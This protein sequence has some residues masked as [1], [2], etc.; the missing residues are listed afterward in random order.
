MST[1]TWK[2]V[3]ARAR[4]D[5]ARRYDAKEDL[6]S[7]AEG[8]GMTLDHLKRQIR[9]YKENRHTLLD[10]EDSPLAQDACNIIFGESPDEPEI[11]PPTGPFKL[12]DIV[13]AMPGT[14]QAFWVRRLQRLQAEKKQITVMHLHDIHFPFHNSQALDVAYQL[15]KHTQ[16]DIIV[17]GSDSSDF[18]L[19]S[20]FAP[21]PDYSEETP[22]ELEK[23]E[24]HWREHIRTLRRLAPN[25]IL[26]FI[27]GNHEV[28]IFKYLAKNAAKLRRTVT[29]AFVDIVRCEGNVLYLGHEVD[30]VRI[31]P[32]LVMH[33]NR[34]GINPA[35]GIF[36]DLGG[37]VWVQ[38]GHN[39]RLSE[40]K[41]NGE[42]RKCGAIGSGCLQN[43]PHYVSGHGRG[44]EQLGTSVSYVDFETQNVQIDNLWFNEEWD[45]RVWVN[46]ER[47][48]F[49]SESAIKT[50]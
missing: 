25:A 15:V 21:D 23:F 44:K 43:P 30:W 40:H 19:L 17:V 37:Q 10:N 28:R 9:F 12:T 4:E 39:H 20:S 41:I 6:T 42:D 49:T 1:I 27:Y 16:P 18:A 8:L 33:G 3:P 32:L 26:V 7:I 14:D 47:K 11:F 45:G 22:D 46:Y 38:F 29:K 50:A 13:R 5:L 36:N 31:G 34:F 2:H 24:M 48:N 35:K